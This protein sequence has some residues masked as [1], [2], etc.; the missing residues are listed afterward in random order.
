[1]MGI[2]AFLKESQMK[3][4]RQ[5]VINLILP[6]LGY[7]AVTGV[8]TATLV[9]VYKWCAKHII[10]FSMEGYDY[11]RGH[12]YLLAIVLP[13]LFGLAWLLQ[14][15]YKKWPSVRGGGIP[16]SIGFL[17]GLI[18]F[19]WLR[20]IVGVFA[21][22]L[23]SF[24]VGVPLGNEGPSVQMGTSVGKAALAPFGKK[25]KAW[26]RYAMTGG[27]CVGFTA[28]TG[29]PISGVMFAVEEA[30][31]RISPM[32]LLIATVS[33]VFGRITTELI[34][35]LL[36]ISVMLFPEMELLAMGIQDMWIPVVV[37]VASGLAAVL[38]L[39]YYR[40]VRNFAQKTLGKVK[41]VYKFFAIFLLTLAFGLVSS[42]FIST[43]HELILGLFEGHIALY[44]I[45]LIL[46]VRAT[47]T[48][49]AN[50]N[51]V[52][53][54]IFLPTLAIGALVA[55][56]IAE[57][58]VDGLGLSPEYYSLILVLGLVA[59]IAGMMKM[60]I[61]AIVFA[62]EALSCYHN[63]LYV[64]IVVTAA[65][66]VTE[67]FGAHSINESVLKAR[68][69]E[70]LAGKDR[71]VMEAFVKVQDGAFAVEKQIR[72]IFW[73]ANLFVL[74]VKKN[75]QAQAVVDEHGGKVLHAGDTLH[76][77]FVTYDLQKTKEDILAIVGEQELETQ[78]T[79][80]V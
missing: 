2:S 39:K 38:F 44:M 48:L 21:L 37:G 28:A 79:M 33:V 57:V 72:D 14:W 62:V 68:V 35:P 69:E 63:I 49:F 66:M 77:R 25:Q 50:V 51:G 40:M 54:G 22:S 13:A 36:G 27:A 59:C 73:P 11:L 71:K 41:S 80:N 45:A 9:A 43:G 3:K 34:S 55:G 53:G 29:A 4:L 6:I 58:L 18:S 61:T 76:V 56:L 26:G 46:L 70:H 7:G 47:L 24:L 64:I 10:E 20:N 32:I 15:S 52:T 8:L 42:S 31:E 74:S 1:M 16:T 60:P 78:E 30:H 75:P 5:Y 19:R 65:F 67:L 12:L 23:T 17:R